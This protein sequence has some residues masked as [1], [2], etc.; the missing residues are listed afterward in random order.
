M[1]VTATVV[2]YTKG[3]FRWWLDRKQSQQ[4]C[5]FSAFWVHKMEHWWRTGEGKKAG[6][7]PKSL[8]WCV[9]CDTKSIWTV[10][11]LSWMPGHWAHRSQSRES[12]CF[13]EFKAQIKERRQKARFFHWTGCKE[14]RW[15]FCEVKK[16]NGEAVDLIRTDTTKWH[17][18]V[19]NF[20]NRS[21]WGAFGCQVI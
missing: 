1:L 6:E 12:P 16:K 14:S 9:I 2:F 19:C 15:I 5:L 3:T 7:F 13:N 11:I 18:S 17:G 8:L 4:T 10:S 20:R 21:I